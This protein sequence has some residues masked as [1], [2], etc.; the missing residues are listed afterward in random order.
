MI[1][2]PPQIYNF[3]QRFVHGEYERQGAVIGALDLPDGARVVELGCGTGLL[4]KFFK[5]GTY[6][7]VDFDA[8]RIAT[9][10]ETYPDHT[11]LVG[12]TTMMTGAWLAEF[13]MAMCHGFIHHVDDTGVGR[14]VDAF[15][16]AARQRSKPFS[17][18]A[19]EPVLPAKAISNPVG[20]ML[21]KFDRGEY[22]RTIPELRTLFG[23]AITKIEP[24][25]TPVQWPVPGAA[26]HLCYAG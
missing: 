20:Y 23:E 21:A 17:F 4:S 6:V 11:F 13:D 9:A 14:M 8:S 25:R 2:L 18:L 1:D 7:G 26:V 10:R 3:L 16:E 5:P 15:R 22:V 24:L 19:I 12:D